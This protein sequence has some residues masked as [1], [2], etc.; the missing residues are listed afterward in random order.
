MHARFALALAVLAVCLTPGIAAAATADA[1]SRALQE[2]PVFVERGAGVDRGAAADAVDDVRTDHGVDLR[3]AALATAPPVG[4]ESMAQRLAQRLPNDIVVVLSPEG[5]GYWS[6]TY[7]PAALDE[8]ADAAFDAFRDGDVPA[9]IRQ[10]GAAVADFGQDLPDEDF[11]DGDGGLV[12]SP[13]GGGFPVLAVVVLVLLGAGAVALFRGSRTTRVATEQ[14]LAEAQ[15]EVRRQVDALAERILSL[16]DRVTLGPPEAQEAYAKATADFQQ[17]SQGLAAATTEGELTGLN[18]ELDGARWQLEVATALL[19]GKPP[20]QMP[21]QH[22]ACFFDP[23]HGAGV[24]QATLTTTAGAREVGVCDYCAAKLERGEAPEA[25]QVSV[26]GQSIPIGMAPREY[27]GRGMRDLDA[28]SILF[29]RGAAVP[30]RWGRR[31]AQP[32]RGGWGGRGRG[33]GFG[34]GGFGGGISGGGGGRSFGGGGGGRRG[35]SGGGGGGRGFG[36]GGRG[37]GGGRKF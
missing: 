13:G 21:A 10:F 23:D 11:G 16:S 6:T 27:G 1:V 3:F 12:E 19:D 31:Y 33:G 28:F 7:D 15:A 30:Y 29:G 36:G 20:P 2:A 5:F 4:E 32:R 8:A 14:R 35:F 25:R 37:G 22:E 9:G 17:A 24:K 34:G 26:D 18:D